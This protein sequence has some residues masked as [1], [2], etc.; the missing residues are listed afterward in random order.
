MLAVKE[1]SQLEAESVSGSTEAS[2]A[3]GCKTPVKACALWLFLRGEASTDT[4]RYELRGSHRSNRGQSAS[5]G[6]RGGVLLINGRILCLRNRFIYRL[7]ER[8]PHLRRRRQHRDALF[9]LRVT[10][11]LCHS[12]SHPLCLLRLQSS[13]ASS[14]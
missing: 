4:K 12:L 8:C 11:G 7:T 14:V 10:S 3:F 2:N 6:A 9:S 5:L 13:S 1:I